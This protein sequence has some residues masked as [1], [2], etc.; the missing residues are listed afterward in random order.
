MELERTCNS[1][2]EMQYEVRKKKSEIERCGLVVFLED[3]L[4]NYIKLDRLCSVGVEMAYRI[5]SLQKRRSD[6]PRD[7][8]V[9]LMNFRMKEAIVYRYWAKEKLFIKGKEIEILSDIHP[10]I[11][12]K[13]RNF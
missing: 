6:L 12:A 3:I 8:I 2:E 13:R 1:L 11:L 4:A 9:K 7:I 10:D 5:G